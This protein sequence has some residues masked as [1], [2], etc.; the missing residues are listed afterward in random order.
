MEGNLGGV[1]FF[2]SANMSF[3]ANL[4]N[5]P[6]AKVSFLTVAKNTTE[7]NVWQSSEK[8]F[9]EKNKFGE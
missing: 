1:K 4:P 3:A 6:A 2:S 9:D 7:S 8:C 5:F